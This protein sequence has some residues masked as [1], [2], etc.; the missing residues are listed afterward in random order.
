MKSAAVALQ[1]RAPVEFSGDVQQALYGTANLAHLGRGGKAVIFK[2]AAKLGQIGLDLHH[3]Y[4]VAAMAQMPLRSAA[5][6]AEY[7]RLLEPSSVSQILNLS[8]F[9]ASFPS[10]FTLL[11]DVLEKFLAKFPSID[12][13]RIV[14]LRESLASGVRF[15]TQHAAL[16][17]YYA[18]AVAHLIEGAIWEFGSEPLLAI[19]DLVFEVPPPLDAFGENPIAHVDVPLLQL[20]KMIKRMKSAFFSTPDIALVLSEPSEPFFYELSVEGSAFSLKSAVNPQI[21]RT[22]QPPSSCSDTP[23]HTSGEPPPAANPPP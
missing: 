11:F 22:P 3:S 9:S 10:H 14:E 16:A 23:E 8:G 18:F 7:F 15:L 13:R 4:V 12:P 21:R 6:R 1:K 17:V 2:R 19:A 20:A 5:W